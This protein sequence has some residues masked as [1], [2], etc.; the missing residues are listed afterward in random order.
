MTMKY[1]KVEKGKAYYLD[2]DN[3]FQE[4]DSIQKDDMLH[5]LDAIT[6][7]DIDFEMDDCI[8]EIQNEAHLIIYKEL[9]KRLSELQDNKDKFL[10]E[11]ESLYKD[12]L[13][14][15]QDNE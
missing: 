8:E 6:N 1:L 5:L 11:S 4:I 12:A 15:Y 9:H 14:K 13:Q 3:E 2:F 10:D 7:K